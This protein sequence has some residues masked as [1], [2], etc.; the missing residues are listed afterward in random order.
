MPDDAPATDEAA[1]PDDASAAPGGASPM[2]DDTPARV[3]RLDPILAPLTGS[4]TVGVDVRYEDA[5]QEL[6]GEVDAAQSAAG[7]ADYER[8]V[9]L[10]TSILS[11]ESKDLTTACYLG[12]GLLR[13][14]GLKGLGEGLDAVRLLCE[15]FWDDFFPPVKRMAA[16]KNAIQLLV[17]RA[18]EWLDAYRPQ[19][20]DAERLAQIRAGVEEFQTFADERMAENAPVFSRL[21]QA[22]ESKQ[23]AAEKPL[24]T[25]SA[26][27]DGGDDEG[28]PAVL[29]SPADAATSVLVAATFLR[30]LDRTDATPY[31]LS[32]AVR[33]GGLR[34]LPPNQDG[35]TQLPAYIEQRKIFLVGRLEKAEFDTLINDAETSF[36]DSP[37]WLDLQRYLYTAMEALGEPFAAAREVILA[38]TALLIRRFPDLP[39]L[40][41]NSGAP[42]A[43]SDTHLWLDTRVISALGSGTSEADLSVADGEEDALEAR[44]KEAR[45]LL[46]GG[47]L[48]GALALM[49]EGEAPGEAGRDSFRR[50]L[51]VAALCRQG[52][53]VAVARAV[54]EGLDAEIDR[55]GVSAWEPALALRAWTALHACY[56]ALA[57]DGSKDAQASVRQ[58]A[59]RLVEKVAR[60][61]PRQALTLL[62]KK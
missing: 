29:S 42:F 2:A 39:A 12:L 28:G 17:D 46:A 9:E 11:N 7:D 55:A 54:L 35:K 61:A 26:E 18:R 44:Y 8:V 3:S 45:Q 5:F 20:P 19:A 22:L 40:T 21:I 23:V 13:T 25:K 34:N 59:E 27:D 6:K 32:R 24:S 47:D 62:D 14:E 38:E 37:F 58:A 52:G 16:R 15:S 50:Q 53:R 48:E 10:A 36:L 41:F 60:L 30:E 33:W 51:Y 4:S 49:A 43:D 57:R 1:V 56:T 31:R